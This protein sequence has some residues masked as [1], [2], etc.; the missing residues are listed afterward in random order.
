MVH[1]PHYHI[2]THYLLR[3]VYIPKPI[4]DKLRPLGIPTV[5]D[6]VIYQAVSTILILEYDL[7]FS[8]HSYGLRP[9][10][11]GYQAI[12]EALGHL[13]EVR[14]WVVDFDIEKYFETVNHDKIIV[15]RFRV[16]GN[17]SGRS[18]SGWGTFTFGNK[19][20]L[21]TIVPFKG[22][23]VEPPNY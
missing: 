1:L 6:R 14:I 11:D 20:I 22:D 17:N 15:I 19:P 21:P 13:N 8:D 7:Y 9:H 18:R 16:P 10:G 5:V 4:S 23:L 2:S 3:R 12:R